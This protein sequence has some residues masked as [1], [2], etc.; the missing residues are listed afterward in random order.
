MSREVPSGWSL[1]TLESFVE[2]FKVLDSV[3]NLPPLSV[4]KSNGIVFQ[5]EKFNKRIANASSS[6]YKVVRSG[7]Y[8][9]DPM[10]LYYG[11]I[12]RLNVCDAGIVSPAYVTFRLKGAIERDFFDLYVKTSDFLVEVNKVTEGGNQDG[13]RKKTD[14][15]SF[16]SLPISVPP[17]HE[18]R[19]IAETLSSVDAAIAATRAVIEQTRN[20]KQGVL[21][22]LLT[23]GIGHTRFKETEIGEIP[24]RWEVFQVSNVAASID[25]GWSP[26]CEKVA[27]AEG[28]WGIL[29]TSAVIWDGYRPNENKKLPGNLTPRPEIEVKTGDVLITRAGPVDRTGVVALVTN[30]PE[31]LMLSDKIIRI[32]TNP[33]QC[34]P[35]FLSLWLSS[36]A[37]QSEVVKKKSGM[38][39]SQTNISQKVLRGLCVPLPPID[40]QIKIAEAVQSVEDD[41]SAENK[42]LGALGAAKTALMSDLLTGR[43]RVSEALSMAAE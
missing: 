24:E 42:K 30:T 10:S 4:T 36:A 43:K 5:S 31:R 35:G 28:E 12:G 38:A 8:S 3:G 2:E 6:N 32:Q 27:A 9:Y 23:K 19:R 39:Q 33:A 25:S 16:C 1:A 34:L 40:E 7:E 17:L 11:A 15:K 37:A 21:E 29:K 41:I 22:R 13:K 26:D 18:Q 20:V 14:W